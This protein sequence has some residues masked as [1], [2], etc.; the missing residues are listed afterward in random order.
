[1]VKEGKRKTQGQ[2][3]RQTCAQRS[4]LPPV[5][6][7]SWQ[8]PEKQVLH[9]SQRSS[10]KRAAGGGCPL[11]PPEGTHCGASL[12]GGLGRERQQGPSVAPQWPQQKH[13]V[14]PFPGPS[15]C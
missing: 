2:V 9:Q 4:V 10:G 1:M 14:K 15:A 13:P 6:P 7:G 8:G 5:T 12:G 3:D 11:Q